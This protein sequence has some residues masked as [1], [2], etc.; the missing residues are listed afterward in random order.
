M[1]SIKHLSLKNLVKFL[2]RLLSAE[3]SNK[4]K[5][6]I[7]KINKLSEKDK[8]NYI[9]RIRVVVCKEKC[10]CCGRICGKED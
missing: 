10:P 5:E 9:N 2:K 1:K 7:D 6:E 8:V 4:L 3:L